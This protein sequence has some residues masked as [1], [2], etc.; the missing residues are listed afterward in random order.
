[1]PKRLSRYVDALRLGALI[2]A[3]STNTSPLIVPYYE[4]IQYQQGGQA[5][6]AFATSS[7]IFLDDTLSGTFIIASVS[8]VFGTTSTSGTLQVEVATGTQATGSGVNQFTGV[9]SLAGTANTTVNGTLLAAPTQISAGSRVN[10]IFG[11]VATGLANCCIT[12]ALQR[13]A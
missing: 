10:V 13:I 1:M 7:T 5:A 3:K 2:D 4:T 9:V 8:A 11:G 12:V 6:A